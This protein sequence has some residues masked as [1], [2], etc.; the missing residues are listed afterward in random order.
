MI[1]TT[2][3]SGVQTLGHRPVLVLGLLGTRPHSRMTGGQASSVFT[4]IPHH[5]HYYL[6]S[7][8]C[9]ISSSIINVM[10]LNHPE[11]IP[12]FPTHNICGKIVF[13][14]T[15][16]CCQKKLGT[17]ELNESQFHADQRSLTQKMKYCMISFILLEKVNVIYAPSK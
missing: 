5:S 2:I 1:Y 13:H 9:Q 10:L 8:S 4:V 14:E 7:T 16:P 6:S 17:A 11:I 12:I 3:K 15:R